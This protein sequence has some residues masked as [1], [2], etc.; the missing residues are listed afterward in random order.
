MNC[1]G[2]MVPCIDNLPLFWHQNTICC[3]KLSRDAAL[4]PNLPQSLQYTKLV[5]L[6]QSLP[7]CTMEIWDLR[8][9]HF[10]FWGKVIPWKMLCQWHVG[11]VLNLKLGPLGLMTAITFQVGSVTMFLP[12]V[13]KGQV[14]LSK[15]H[16]TWRAKAGQ[17]IV[18]TCAVSPFPIISVQM[19]WGWT[20][21]N[22]D[23]SGA[24]ILSHDIFVAAN[25]CLAVAFEGSQLWQGGWEPPWRHARE[26]AF[27]G[28]LDA[29]R[30]QGALNWCT[31]LEMKQLPIR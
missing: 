30:C 19:N 11:V 13:P 21:I 16:H 31:S 5:V 26:W 3:A 6:K 12:E 29:G 18:E 23:K 10:L 25:V 1:T 24:W 2:A 22:H 27:H 8:A 15:L 17:R 28:S 14:P 9:S 20:S 7:H 4:G